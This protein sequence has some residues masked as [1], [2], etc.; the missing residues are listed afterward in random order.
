[1]SDFEAVQKTG[2]PFFCSLPS[3]L[4]PPRF[5]ASFAIKCPSNISQTAE[6]V[7]QLRVVADTPRFFSKEI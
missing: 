5:G 1:M 6:M 4:P 2:R 7:F 3:G